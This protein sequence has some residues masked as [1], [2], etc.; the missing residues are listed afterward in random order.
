MSKGSRGGTI[1]ALSSGSPPAAIAVVRISGP[2]AGRTLA[3]L[4]GTLPEPRRASLRRLFDPADGTPLD[5]ALVLWFPGPETATGEDLGELHLHGGR[6]VVSAV[7]AALD[8]DSRLSLAEPGQFTRRAFENGRLDLVEAEGLAD[9]LSAETESQRRAAL[10]IAEGVLSRRLEGWRQ[11][12][13][14]AAARI[15]AMLDFA[16]EDDVP[17]E[18]EEGRGVAL[19]LAGE[20]EALLRAPPAE[21]LRDGVRVVIAGPPNAGKSTLLNRLAGRDAAITAATAGT[22]R[23]VIEVPV[24]IGGTPFLLIDTAGLRDAEDEIE[25]I[26]VARAEAAVAT[27]DIVLWLGDDAASRDDHIVA[28][29]A[30]ADLPGRHEAPRDSVRVSAHTGEGLAELV[31]M[32]TDRARALLPRED[33]MALNVRQRR[34]LTD[35][36]NNLR[37]CEASADP[38]V[39]AE[40]LRLARAALDCTTGRAGVEDMLDALF[41]RFCIGK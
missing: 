26:G 20:I 2:D 9:L 33:E 11:A 21:R 38:L 5:R 19:T 13:L 1:F 24:T 37:L 32:M 34:A 27:A 10:R 25:Q 8:R 18:D 12:V 36:M 41:G 31:V 28:V 35:V 14:T 23:D 22:T 40:A 15:E 6:A 16:D 39:V 17:E 29:H 3:S 7:L 30:R 4:A